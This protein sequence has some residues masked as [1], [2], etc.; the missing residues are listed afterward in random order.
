MRVA[1]SDIVPSKD[2]FKTQAE[3]IQAFIPFPKISAKRAYLQRA[4]ILEHC[5]YA[6]KAGVYTQKLSPEVNLSLSE[7]SATD[8]KVAQASFLLHMTSGDNTAEYENGVFPVKTTVSVRKGLEKRGNPSVLE[9]DHETFQLLQEEGAKM[10]HF[11]EREL[12]GKTF[13]SVE[14]IK[15]PEIVCIDSG[16]GEGGSKVLTILMVSIFNWGRGGSKIQPFF[17]L[18]KFV[19]NK[20][21][22]LQPLFSGVTLNFREFFNL[23][24][25]CAEY[26]QLVEQEMGKVKVIHDDIEK[27]MKMKIQTFLQHHPETNDDSPNFIYDDGDDEEVYNEGMLEEDLNHHS[28]AEDFKILK[29]AGFKI[30]VGDDLL[31]PDESDLF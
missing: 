12:R 17:N 18:R 27:V 23:I 31:K 26:F 8:Q 5:V 6:N 7:K 3:K 11:V 25:P 13:S 16:I 9:M 14:E 20:E 1:T 4:F 10:L 24:F 15:L 2:G 28:I 29:P 19:E 21:G 30:P 22:K